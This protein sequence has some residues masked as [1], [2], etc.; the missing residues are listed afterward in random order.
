M[1][2]E[3]EDKALQAHDVAKT[4]LP[5][6]ITSTP[7]AT[8]DASRYTRV[9]TLELEKF[10]ISNDGTNAEATSQGINAALQHAKTLQAN[11]IVFPKGTYLIDENNPILLDHQDTIVDLGG[12]TLQVRTNG[13][14]GYAVVQ[15]LPGAKNLRLT[16]GTIRGDREEHDYKAARGTHE[17]GHCI[18]IVGGDELEIDHLHLTHATGDGLTASSSGAR[19]REELLAR[20]LHNVTRANL[21]S[22]AF[23]EN[24]EKIDSEEKIRTRTSYPLKEGLKTFELGYLAG[25]QGFPWIKGRTYQAYFYDRE[26]RFLGKKECL[27]YRKV[28]VPEGARFVHFEFNQPDVDTEAAHSGAPGDWLVRVNNFTPPTNVHV[29]HNLFDY[30]RRLGIGTVGQRWVIEENRFENNGGTPPSYGIDLEDGWE[31]MQDIV[32]RKNRFR[33]NKLGDIVICAGSELLVEENEFTNKVVFHGRA[34]NYTVRKNHFSGGGVHYSTRTGIATISDNTYENVPYISITFD[35][36]KVADGFVRKPGE[37]I[38]TPPLL[39]TNETVVGVKNIKGT[40]LN[41]AGGKFRD[42]QFLADEKT[43]LVRIENAKLEQCTLNVPNKG[44]KV[45]LELKK[46][47]GDPKIKGDGAS[48]IVRK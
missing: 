25:Y 46:N 9:Y 42:C 15:I 34:Y 36:K 39:L 1:P 30:N 23:S 17:G 6:T 19:N 11:K 5:V 20:I 26:Q 31:L 12:S 14:P 28:E 27:Q 21:E 45:V 4:I 48:R 32:I 37:T 44:G 38:A 16:N 3:A 41:F 35:N 10:G 13:R 7:K 2:P 18:E 24:G 33:N 40:Y 8:A 29:H 43:Y 47:Q 22:G